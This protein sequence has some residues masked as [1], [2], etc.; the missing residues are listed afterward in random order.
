[1]WLFQY[2][3]AH[4]GK[5]DYENFYD[6]IKTEEVKQDRYKKLCDDLYENNENYEY[7]TYVMFHTYIIKWLLIY[8]K[9]EK[10]THGMTMSPLR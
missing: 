6:F 3:E 7:T 9:I 1:V 5:F 10:V 2:S 4:A 8:S